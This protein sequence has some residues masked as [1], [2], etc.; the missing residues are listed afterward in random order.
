MIKSIKQMLIAALLA[1]AAIGVVLPVPAA[2]KPAPADPAKPTRLPFG[3]KLKAIDKI[4]K[5]ITIDREK[6]NTFAIT[7]ETKITKAG[8]PATLDEAIVGENVGGLAV[9]KNGKLEL[10]SLRLG[11]KPV[12]KPDEQPKK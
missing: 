9:D 6:K 1:A 11:A 3:G 10:L 5:T 4:A 12:V 2:D 8:K 7:S